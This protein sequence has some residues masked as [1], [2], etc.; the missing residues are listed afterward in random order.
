MRES[1]TIDRDKVVTW[2]TICGENS[3][4]SECCPY[5]AEHRTEDAIECMSALM[6]DALELLKEEPEIVRCKDC[7]HYHY[8]KDQIPYCDDIDYGYGW[9]DDD[10]CSHAERR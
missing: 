1:R 5:H 4:C 7:K 6:R 2:L 3:D 10:F 8:D 9:R